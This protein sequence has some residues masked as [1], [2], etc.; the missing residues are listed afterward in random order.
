MSITSLLW[1]VSLVVEKKSSGVA[2]LHSV[3]PLVRSSQASQVVGRDVYFKMDC[4]QPPGSFKIRGIGKVVEEAAKNAKGVVSSSGGNAGLAT[5]YAAQRLGV[6]C[7]V[8]LPESTPKEVCEILRA[9]Y[10]ARVVVFGSVWD[11]AN[12]EAKRLASNAQ[13]V[14]PFDDRIAWEG[15]ASLVSEVVD[16]LGGA[17]PDCFVASVGGGG[18]LAGILEGIEKFSP[19]T[20][21]VVA[22]E[23]L[24]A[25][26]FA[27]SMEAGRALPLEGGSIASIAKSLG[28]VTP[29]QTVV[30]NSLN[31]GI[32]TTKTVSDADA[33]K[34]CLAFA[35][36]HR[37]LVE[38]AC[39]ASLATVYDENYAKELFDDE[40]IQTIVVEVCGGAVVDL[41]SLLGWSRRLGLPPP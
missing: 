2:M 29:S 6:D 9:N 15:H 11:E 32:V 12:E 19:S 38:P 24:G 1:F 20:R 31:S 4:L 16:Q 13:L 33:V 26:S 3:T 30:E 14:H 27:R 34:A 39:G 28:A 17:R 35:D 5:A 7:T 10:G 23:T 18:L 37:H 8:V 41:P 22:V 25:D 40:S 36:E 21:R